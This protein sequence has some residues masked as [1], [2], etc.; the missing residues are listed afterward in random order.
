M[1]WDVGYYLIVISRSAYLRGEDCDPDT[2]DE[3]EFIDGKRVGSQEQCDAAVAYSADRA[4][5]RSSSRAA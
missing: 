5:T 2:D 1:I 4:V 3:P